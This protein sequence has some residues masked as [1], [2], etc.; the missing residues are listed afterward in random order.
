MGSKAKGSSLI[1]LEGHV[2]KVPMERV[3]TF[4]IATYNVNSL[5]SRLPIVIEWLE[6]HRPDILCIQE[7]KVSDESFPRDV[8]L[9]KGYQVAYCGRKQYNGVATFSL[10]V[11]DD[12]SYGFKDGG[13]PDGDRLIITRFGALV[14]VNTY[15]PQGRERGTEHFTYKLDWF[16]RLKRL[17]EENFS[18]HDKIIWC[19]DLNV[20][21]EPIDVHDPKRLLG[22]VDFNPEVWECFDQVVSFGFVDLFRLVHP[23]EVGQYT[24]FDYRVPKVVERKLGWRVDHILATHDLAKCLKD[25]YI[26]MGPRLGKKPSDHT[27]LVA[28]FTCGCLD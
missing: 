8:F 27:V 12:V 19:G 13:P 4:K 2:R 22:H 28:E 5:R 24:F 25:C 16:R 15:V 23:G 18:P 1:F 26:D 17:F 14:V 6:A 21:R 3:K 10:Q 11:P 20:A 7:T 9:E